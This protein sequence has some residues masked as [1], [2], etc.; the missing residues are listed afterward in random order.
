MAL[1]ILLNCH[2]V[3]DKGL[4]I[5]EGWAMATPPP[6]PG[7]CRVANLLM[8]GPAAMHARR[9]YPPEFPPMG[10]ISFMEVFG[11]L[12]N[13]IGAALFGLTFIRVRS[14]ELKDRTPPPHFAP[15]SPSQ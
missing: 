3:A 2:A 4:G 11:I 9:R 15:P 10:L 13:I 6:L 7:R 5:P 1:L 8:R 12:T 14:N